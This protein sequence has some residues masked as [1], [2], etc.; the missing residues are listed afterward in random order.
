MG[1]SH[2]R[3]C[4]AAT[5]SAFCGM[6]I[7]GWRNCQMWR[8]PCHFLQDQILATDL[9]LHIGNLRVIQGALQLSS[10]PPDLSFAGLPVPNALV[11]AL[12][13]KALPAESPCLW[14]DDT[15]YRSLVITG[16]GKKRI[17]RG[18]G[19]GLGHQVL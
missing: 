3:D 1:V 18:E 11:S 15:Y 12:W 9:E 5:S 14:R 7:P 16:L 17:L 13:G 2:W 10:H 4:W 8:D 6:Y 19:N